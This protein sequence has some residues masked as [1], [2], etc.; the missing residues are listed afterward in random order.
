M[1]GQGPDERVEQ[2]P[3]EG[4]DFGAA[5]SKGS[6]TRWLVIAKLGQDVLCGTFELRK[7]DVETQMLWRLRSGNRSFTDSYEGTKP[8]AT[9]FAEKM[10]PSSMRTWGL[11]RPKEDKR[12]LTVTDHKS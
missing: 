10:P 5:D 3:P 4:A 7:P 12:W 8:L 6:R 2:A 11:S 1:R 9:E